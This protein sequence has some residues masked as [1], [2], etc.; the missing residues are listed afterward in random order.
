M[1]MQ[2]TPGTRQFKKF[3]LNVA[4]VFF[5]CY[6]FNIFYVENIKVILRAN[7]YTIYKYL[8]T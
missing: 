7:Q 3:Y 5:F 1:F 2:G 4:I 6:W 8:K